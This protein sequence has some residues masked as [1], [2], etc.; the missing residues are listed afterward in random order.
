MFVG[1]L[2]LP[3][4]AGDPWVLVLGRISDNPK[5]HY[6]PLK[7]LLDYV[8][9]R[10]KDVGIHEGRVLMAKDAGQMADYLRHGRI[11]WI[12]GTAAA[13]VLLKQHGARPILLA[14]RGGAGHHHTVFFTRHDSGVL[15]PD[16]LRGR[17]IAFQQPLSTTAYFLPA[18]ELL[19]RGNTLELLRL[20]G[21][22]PGPD[23]VGYVF[24]RSEANIAAWVH[25]RLVDAG[26]LSN[27]D[28]E[29][30]RVVPA[31]FRRDLHVIG[32][33][34]SVPRA[35][36]LV[37]GDLDPRIE[38]RLRTVL[39][40]ASDDP[41]A[42]DALLGYYQTTRFLPMDTDSRNELDVLADGVGR[43]RGSGK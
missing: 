7:A 15:S 33:T 23:A 10:M 36:E 21:D 30:P 18:A 20:P 43:V 16:D 2:P 38:A 34:D 32:T 31:A 6:E 12:T 8:V 29:N 24:A 11:D 22:R 5:A 28:W 27:L 39:L 13:G 26:T 9:P 19:R 40:D 42:R 41:E 25:K 1:L 14:E 3:A 35:L 37:R 17:R 4:A